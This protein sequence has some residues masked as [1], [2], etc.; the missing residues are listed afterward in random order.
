MGLYYKKANGILQN[1][2]L[3]RLR[4]STYRADKNLQVRIGK[5]RFLQVVIL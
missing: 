1:C 3:S 5:S 4:Y 2:L